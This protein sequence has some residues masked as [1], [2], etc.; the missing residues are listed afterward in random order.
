MPV[1]SE[2]HG[3]KW[4]VVDDKGKSYGTH[5]SKASAV[6][7]VQAINISEGLAP[8]VKPRTKKP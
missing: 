4:T 8:G 6:K 7:Q 1:H 2:K 5:N 3:K